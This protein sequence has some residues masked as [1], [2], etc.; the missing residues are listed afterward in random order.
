MLAAESYWQA[1]A[2]PALLI[3][4]AGVV[5]VALLVRAGDWVIR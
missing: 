1:A 5:P 4:L 2:I 3:V